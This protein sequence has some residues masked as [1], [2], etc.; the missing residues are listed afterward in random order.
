MR[1]CLTIEEFDI[2]GF[3]VVRSMSSGRLVRQAPWWLKMGAKLLLSR[4]PISY[5]QWRNLGLFHHG[6]MQ[7]PEYA[8]E[9]FRAHYRKCEGM[10]P[11]R[12]SCIE[13]GPGDSLLSAL[14]ASAH[15]ATT[16]VLIDS[17]AFADRGIEPY[18]EM[19]R[20]LAERG[21][22]VPVGIQSASGIDEIADVCGA[23]YLTR[24]LQS[25][26]EIPSASVDFVWSQAVLEH[27]RAKEFVPL[28]REMRRVMKP[29]GV[30]SHRIDLKDHL[31][32]ALNNLRIGD[33]LWEKEWFAQSGF[34][35]NRFRFSE[36][37]SM[38]RQSRFEVRV[39]HVDRWGEL[40]THRRA[41]IRRFRDSP[42]EELLISGF[43]V[44]LF[45]V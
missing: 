3:G 35:T 30:A 14:C 26:R 23:R 44:L 33:G 13:V 10:L 11:R 28:L 19:A 17:N 38:F 9:V 6:A 22:L 34:Y 18:L 20:F 7:S 16:T 27:I 39:T 4:L 31:G 36:I 25:W 1:S 5:D 42:M 45:P 37:C 8:Y 40:P 2:N 32:G 21:L 29:T 15:G 12:F 24:G 41:M 43:E